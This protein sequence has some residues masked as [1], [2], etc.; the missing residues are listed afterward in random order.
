VPPRP[1]IQSKF[2]DN[3]RALQQ[4]GGPDPLKKVVGHYFT[5][6]PL[7]LD[8]IHKGI[9]NADPTSIHQAAHSLKSSSANLGAL[10]L[11]DLCK[12]M[13]SLGRAGS[14]AG[15]AELMVQIESAYGAVRKELLQI[16][17]E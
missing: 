8:T 16:T 2:L 6:S 7:L 1:V 3:I 10:N 5:S 13:E 4:T 11:S 9:A 12:K 14:I 17:Q 15:A